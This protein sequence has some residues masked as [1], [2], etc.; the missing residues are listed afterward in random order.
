MKL[1]NGGGRAARPSAAALVAALGLALSACSGNDNARNSPSA[2]G[3]SSTGGTGG[4][5][6]GGTA[7]TGGTGGA[8]G[9]GGQAA[10]LKP[11]TPVPDPGAGAIWFA[12][13]GEVLALTGYPFPP[14][15][16]GDPAFVD[17]WDVQF[18]HLLVTV[19]HVKISED[20]DTVP[21]DESKTGKLVGEV[22]GPWAIDLSYSDPNY[23][24]GKGGGGEEAVP[25]AALKNQN[26]NGGAAFKTDGTRYAFG[27]DDVAATSKAM[28][29]NLNGDALS[30]YQQMMQN[31]CV[32][33]YDGTA[34]F[35]GDGSCNGDP[36]YKDWPKTVH[37]KFCFKSPTSYINCQN[38]DNDPAAPLGNEEHQRGIA[39]SS[40]AST[41][42]QVTFH[43]DHPFWDSV[44]HD[45]PA[46]FDQFAAQ[47][48]GSTDPDPTVTL[49]MVKG[50]DYTAMTDAK[51]NALKWRYC[52]TPPTDVHAQFT[53]AMAFDPESVPHAT[54]NDP[55]TGLRDYYDFSTYDPSTQ[56]HLNSDGLCFVKRNY[57]SP[58]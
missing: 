1:F 56:G 43:T 24:P 52:M 46:H 32:V 28:N 21:G 26:K 55:S 14:T 49:D 33:Y 17:G 9:S 5:G 3:S 38:P 50:K 22:D 34:T 18:S 29:V 20:P 35:K 45:S 16:P 58:Q 53:G 12:A 48:A 4:N 19:D 13:S 40:T 37:F 8:G 47:L 2:G 10:N 42:A 25:F 54:G 31:Q 51:G 41:V 39:L 57:P 7:A 44:L 30:D 27:F 6:S 36:E 11:F 23:L 15:N